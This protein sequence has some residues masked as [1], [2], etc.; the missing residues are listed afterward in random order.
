MCG[1]KKEFKA[2]CRSWLEVD[3]IGTHFLD[4]GQ[5]RAKQ[6]VNYRD[7]QV[8]ELDFCVS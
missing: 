7:P 6:K 2:E 3:R 1:G 5:D 8:L 4:M